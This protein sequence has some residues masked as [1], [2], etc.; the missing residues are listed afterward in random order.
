MGR[1]PAAGGRRSGRKW[2][3]AVFH[4]R[5]RCSSPRTC[6]WRCGRRTIRRQPARSD[7][8]PQPGLPPRCDR[9]AQPSPGDPAGARRG[10]GDRG[11]SEHT[12]ADLLADELADAARSTRP[13]GPRSRGARAGTPPTGLPDG[14]EAQPFLLQLGT[15]FK[16]KN[17]VFALELLS[18]LRD[19]QGWM[20][21]WRSW[22]RT[23]PTAP[24]A[25]RSGCPG[26]GAEPRRGRR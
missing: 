17:R 22:A 1:A 8:V 19:G 15:D 16:H 14:F 10:R 3:T 5:S 7:R 11:V 24:R 2:R 6:A 20:G 4:G 26:A 12:R 18:A 9:V 21:A 13:P 23:F 25:S